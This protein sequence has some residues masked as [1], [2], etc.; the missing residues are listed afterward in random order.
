MLDTYDE[1]SPN[2]P[3]NEAFAFEKLEYT[4]LEEAQEY[5]W[6]LKQQ[7]SKLASLLHQSESIREIVK[8]QILELIEESKDF[9]NQYLPNKLKQIKL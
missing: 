9:D 8:E 5:N 1:F 3:I 4:E 7:V 2:N 6:Q